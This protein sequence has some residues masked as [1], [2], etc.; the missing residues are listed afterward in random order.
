[1]PTIT[2]NGMSVLTVVD[3]RAAASTDH[4]MMIIIMPSRVERD[5]RGFAG[6]RPGSMFGAVVC[7]RH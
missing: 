1:L 2:I 3:P 5:P 4:G 7:A 6:Y